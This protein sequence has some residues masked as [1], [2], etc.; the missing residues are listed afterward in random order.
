MLLP[1]TTNLPASSVS[2]TARR[3]KILAMIATSFI[4]VFAFASFSTHVYAL[5]LSPA[6]IE[7][8]GDQER[9]LADNLL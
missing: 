9:R 4:A 8:N 6:R 3:G 2:T 5:T 1:Q 7:I